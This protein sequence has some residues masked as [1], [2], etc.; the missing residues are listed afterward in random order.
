[1]PQSPKNRSAGILREATRLF[2]GRGYEG[3][4]LQAI[5]EAVGIRKPSLLYHFRSKS[6]LRA[7]VMDKLLS[8][9]SE[10]VPQVMAAATTGENRF[11]AAL[12]EALEFFKAHPD[13]ARLLMREVHDQP[14]EMRNRLRENMGPWVA[15]VTHYIRQGQEEGVIYPDLDPEAYV[16]ETIILV[17]G[18]FA[19]SDVIGKMSGD[20]D[21]DSSERRIRE[22]VRI[23]RSSLFIASTPA[24][25]GAGSEKN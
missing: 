22:M 5:A 11:D 4:S 18:T 21:D 7:A 10:V 13:A 6:E 19:V 15:L 3:T 8:R 24:L 23:A 17:C 12:S 20:A 2:A 1:M 25:S 14:D 9:W 16:I